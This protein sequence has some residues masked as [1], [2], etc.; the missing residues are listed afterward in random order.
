MSCWYI[1]QD[2]IDDDCT[3]DGTSDKI[4][5]MMTEQLTYHVGTSDKVTL[6]M[7]VQLTYH[8]GTSEKI[9]LMMIVQQTKHH[10]A[11]NPTH[12]NIILCL[13]QSCKTII[14]YYIKSSSSG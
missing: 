6:M 9:T 11:V 2:S 1:R 7:T 4:T 3:T 8:V 13:Y 10:F 12:K 14:V 5:L